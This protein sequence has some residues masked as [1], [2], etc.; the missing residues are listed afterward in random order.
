MKS[1]CTQISQH[2]FLTAN[3]TLVDEDLLLLTKRTTTTCYSD[4]M[5]FEIQYSNYLHN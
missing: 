4:N 1:A 2:L 5:S 3:C